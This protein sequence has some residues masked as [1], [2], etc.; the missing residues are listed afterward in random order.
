MK[1]L[2]QVD[3]AIDL[4]AEPFYQLTP[5][6]RAQ[7][8][9]SIP[10]PEFRTVLKLPHHDRRVIEIV[11]LLAVGSAVVAVDNAKPHAEPRRGIDLDFP[12]SVAAGAKVLNVR[13]VVKQVARGNQ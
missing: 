4:F 12:G 3:T 5:T 11:L 1:Q 2:D 6:R 10:H 8:Q 13:Q 9:T 7:N